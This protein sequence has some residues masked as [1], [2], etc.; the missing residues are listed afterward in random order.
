MHVPVLEKEVLEFLALRPGD[1]VVDATLGS[2]GHSKA[3]LQA[4]GEAGLLV[5][6]DQDEEAISRARKALEGRP[7]VIIKQN[8]FRDL[9]SVL[10]GLDVKAIDKILFDVGVSR[11]QLESEARGFSF[12]LDGPLDMRMDR[13][14]AMSA[15]D[16]VNTLPVGELADILF[17]FG[18]ERNS[19]KI[20][21]RIVER[22]GRKRFETTGDLADV[23][24]G[25]VPRR[26]RIHPAT[27]SFQAI[28]IAVNGELDALREGLEKSLGLLVTGGRAVV[29]S[30][31][32]LEDRIVKEVFRNEVR[33][34][35]LELL[36]KLVRPSSE[37]VRSNP[38]A[39]S[40]KLRAGVRVGAQN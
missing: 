20:A 35:T 30:Y 19:R 3:I 31:H 8:N 13:G 22:R 27:R 25:C 23:I 14:G 29:L 9:D 10:D 18:D 40:A 21:A 32:S 17:R 39:R 24:A 36:V 33:K 7:N 15:A 38:R 34:G 1:V 5:G 4:I 26:E 16:L 28:R 12:R 11:E 37:E 6:I 2:G